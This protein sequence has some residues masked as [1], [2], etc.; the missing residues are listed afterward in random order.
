[1]ESSV[2]VE[3]SS[4]PEGRPPVTTSSGNQQSTT[5]S[6]LS[7]HFGS[8][9]GS[10]S[11]S[12]FTFGPTTSVNVLPN[13]PGMPPGVLQNIISTMLQQHGMV[14]VIMEAAVIVLFNGLDAS[15][16]MFAILNAL[17]GVSMQDDLN[18][19][20][21]KLSVRIHPDTEIMPSC[22]SK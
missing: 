7:G 20:L 18:T 12:S 22:Q 21:V 13:V 6:S 1:M 16:S 10:T 9:P 2:T 17:H 15:M 8:V 5:T 11:T 14:V 19:K 4:A 3:A